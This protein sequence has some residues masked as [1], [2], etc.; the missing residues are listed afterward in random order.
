MKKK[1]D[2]RTCKHKRTNET[3]SRQ[4]S[5]CLDCGRLGIGNTWLNRRFTIKKLEDSLDE[6]INRPDKEM[7][8]SWIEIAKLK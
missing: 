7:I 4:S 1:K 5:F 2:F 6:F 3:L 8:L